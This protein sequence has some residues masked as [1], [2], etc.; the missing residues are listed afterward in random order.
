MTYKKLPGR[1]SNSEP[2]DLASSTL[3]IVPTFHYACMR[4]LP[5]LNQWAWFTTNAPK[6]ADVAGIGRN[7]RKYLFIVNRIA[8]GREN[9]KT[10]ILTRFWSR[11]KL[12]LF[13]RR[14]TGIILNK[15]NHTG[16]NKKFT[17]KFAGIASNLKD[18][19]GVIY[20][21]ICILVHGYRDTTIMLMIWTISCT[22][23][24]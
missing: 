20:F 3:S 21:R 22:L 7:C 4:P 11:Q 19:H 9:L 18:K 12:F 17:L 10:A 2:L 14:L 15:T 16:R 23:P 6:T 13:S 1:D 24:K 8:P 5:V